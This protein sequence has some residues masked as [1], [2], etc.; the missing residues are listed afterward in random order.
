MKEL[1]AVGPFNH[2]FMLTQEHIQ[3]IMLVG[4]TSLAVPDMQQFGV[5]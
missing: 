2:S 5:L 3:G 1:M 4:E